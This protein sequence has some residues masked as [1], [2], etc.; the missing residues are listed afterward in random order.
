MAQKTV[1]TLYDDLDGTAEKVETVLFALDGRAYEIDLSAVNAGTLRE[2]LADY[3]KAGRKVTAP[4]RAARQRGG[5]AREESAAIRI[6]ARA[7][8]HP[9]S[10]RGRIPETV[11]TAYR[12][13]H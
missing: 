2:V 4:A 5:A 8:G 7:N 6:W 9:V 13:A 12:A 10:N 1:V 3:V 11:M